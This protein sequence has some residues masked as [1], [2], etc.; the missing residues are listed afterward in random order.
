MARSHSPSTAGIDILNTLCFDTRLV[1]KGEIAISSGSW[2]HII[3][4]Q[5]PAPRVESVHRSLQ[6]GCVVY[7]QA[8]DNTFEDPDTG[9]VFQ[10]VDGALPARDV[11][12]ECAQDMR[13]RD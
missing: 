3:P 10:S 6:D 9:N 5:L 7:T 8:A 4:R 1:L 2:P 11:K 13:D 12:V